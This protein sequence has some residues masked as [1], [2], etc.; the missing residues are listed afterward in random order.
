[1]ETLLLPI[2]SFSIC[3]KFSL[4]DQNTRKYNDVLRSHLQFVSEYSVKLLHA[5]IKTSIHHS[6]MLSRKLQLEEITI[7]KENIISSIRNCRISRAVDINKKFI[8][9][10]EFLDPFFQEKRLISQNSILAFIDR[11]YPG[12]KISELALFL[13]SDF[14]ENALI[15]CLKSSTEY[16][17]NIF[18]GLKLPS[19]IKQKEISTL[20]YFF[21]NT[22][23]TSSDKI[24]LEEIT[25]KSSMLSLVL[26][27]FVYSICEFVDINQDYKFI[28][29]LHVEHLLRI[30]GYDFQKLPEKKARKS[31]CIPFKYIFD[32]LDGNYRISLNAVILISNFFTD[33]TIN[34][35]FNTGMDKINK[36]LAYFGI[37]LNSF[38]LYGGIQFF[39]VGTRFEIVE[40]VPHENIEYL[41]LLLRIEENTEEEIFDGIFSKEE[42]ALLE[43]SKD[44]LNFFVNNATP[45]IPFEYDIDTTGYISADGVYQK[46]LFQDTGDY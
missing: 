30:I 36:V 43:R 7:F 3:V 33:L 40:S 15:T 35:L 17:I 42:T 26:S 23:K 9:S 24:T 16:D 8:E 10:T 20:I 44:S 28:D 18:V 37:R 38:L 29:S 31:S 22:K 21:F 19:I 14:L 13:V 25:R 32:L 2:E 34:V 6:A 27:S 11:N 45:S 4:E 12:V 1:M 41:D 5:L 39:S 46:I